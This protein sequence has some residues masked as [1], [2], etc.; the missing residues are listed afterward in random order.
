MQAAFDRWV[1]VGLAPL[2][3]LRTLGLRL[4]GARLATLLR[5]RT[6]RV[7]LWGVGCV[8]LA[9]VLTA[10]APLY[11]LTLGPVLLGVAHLLADVRYLVVRQGLH[12]RRALLLT[13]APLMVAQTWY[14][15]A[16]LAL[17][18]AAVAAACARAS[19]ARRS[20]VGGLALGLSLACLGRPE[21]AAV[22][23]VH[24]HNL[25]ALSLWVWW[26]RRDRWHVVPALIAFAVCTALIFVGELDGAVIG[27]GAQRTSF[28]ALDVHVLMQGVASL[29]DPLLDVRLLLFFAF[30]QSVHYAVWTRLIPEEDR[31]REGPRSYRASY[32]ALARDLDTRFLL[33]VVLIAVYFAARGLLD[34]EVGRAQYLRFALFHG[35]LELAAATIL[36]LEAGPLTKCG[37]K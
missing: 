34:P 22:C 1:L 10:R 5:N 18:T 36:M 7:G 19:L 20:L 8:L 14:P 12:T 2:D 28:L 30:A 6:R 21:V 11:L 37:A 33:G 4:F 25:V 26:A 32:T 23:F 3:Q 35:P 16:A 13:V 15:S 27:S 24:A 31:P 17:C 29:V 9:F